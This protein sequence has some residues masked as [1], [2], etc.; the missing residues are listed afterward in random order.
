[1][2][3]GISTII[4]SI[5]LL[6]ITIGLAGTA[7]VFITGLLTGFYSKVINV[8]DVSCTPSGVP[9]MSN[10]TIILSNDGTMNITD[11]ELTVMVD[12]NIKSDKF[13][14]NTIIPRTTEVA[15][16]SEPYQMNKVHI[17]VV[18]SPSNSIRTEV[19]C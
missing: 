4:A 8:L 3:K 19:W 5:I 16:S 15:T 7:Y 6:I 9:N 13:A 12:N 2:N 1:M 11:S 18:V 17:V 14:F 10:I